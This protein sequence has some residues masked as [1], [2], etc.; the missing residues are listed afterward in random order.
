MMMCA[1]SMLMRD[2]WYSWMRISFED[3]YEVWMCF[4]ACVLLRKQSKLYL[5]AD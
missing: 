4:Y 1:I 2:G 3:D 5:I